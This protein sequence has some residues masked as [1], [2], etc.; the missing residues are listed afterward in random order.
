VTWENSKVED[1][2]SVLHAKVKVEVA[3]LEYSTNF[4]VVV[5]FVF[6]HDARRFS[7]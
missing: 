3:N 7:C 4:T 6:D 2:W 1:T 5:A